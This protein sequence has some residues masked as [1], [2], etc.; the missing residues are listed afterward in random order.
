[1]KAEKNQSR[2]FCWRFRLDKGNTVH[3]Q[4]CYP[5]PPSRFRKYSL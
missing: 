4:E 1:M 5:P 3:A 2:E